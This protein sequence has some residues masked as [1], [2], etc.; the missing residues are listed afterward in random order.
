MSTDRSAFDSHV[1]AAHLAEQPPDATDSSDG[2]SPADARRNSPLSPTVPWPRSHSLFVGS[3]QQQE[4]HGGA[5]S[6]AVK[7]LRSRVDVVGRFRRASF[8]NDGAHQARTARSLNLVRAAAAATTPSPEIAS[9]DVEAEH[10]GLTPGDLEREVIDYAASTDAM[11]RATE[12][13][14]KHKLAEQRKSLADANSELR[15]LREE[16]AGL[17]EKLDVPSAYG[18]QWRTESSET[19]RPL[20]RHRS[21]VLPNSRL[22]SPIPRLESVH[23]S[24]TASAAL[25]AA[26]RKEGDWRLER[27]KL[28]MRLALAEQRLARYDKQHLAAQKSTEERE[29]KLKKQVEELEKKVEE[30]EEEKVRAQDEAE[31]RRQA[32]AELRRRLR[33]W[34]DGLVR[35]GKHAIEVCNKATEG[36]IA[37]TAAGEAGLSAVLKADNARQL[38]QLMRQQLAKC[39]WE[40]GSAAGS[41][42][43]GI[44]GEIGT[45]LER[46]NSAE[47]R[48]LRSRRAGSSRPSIPSPRA[49]TTTDAVS[50]SSYGL[51]R[52]A[53]ASFQ[54]ESPLMSPAPALAA[55]AIAPA[56]RAATVDRGV[57]CRGPAHCDAAA[58]TEP[59]RAVQLQQTESA[60]A[61]RQR[62]PSAPPRSR[63]SP[64][65]QDAKAVP[66]HLLP[67]PADP[68][69]GGERSA[70]S[71]PSSDPLVVVGEHKQRSPRLRPPSPGMSLCIGTRKPSGK[72]AAAQPAP[73]PAAASQ[74]SST[75]DSASPPPAACQVPPSVALLGA[76]RAPPEPSASSTGTPLSTAAVG[77]C[78]AV[79]TSPVL[80]RAESAG[81]CRPGV[82]PRLIPTMHMS[83]QCRAEHAHAPQCSA[84]PQKGRPAR[85]ASPHP[86]VSAVSTLDQAPL[87]LVSPP[88]PFPSPAPAAAPAAAAGAAPRL[89]QFA[90]RQLAACISLWW[91]PR[92]EWPPPLPAQPF[93][94]PADAAWP[95]SAGGCSAAALAPWREPLLALL[96]AWE[97]MLRVRREL[98]PRP[99][100]ISDKVQQFISWLRETLGAEVDTASPR[101]QHHADAICHE[102]DRVLLLLHTHRLSSAEVRGAERCALA[103][104][105]A[106]ATAAT[107]HWQ[108]LFLLQRVAAECQ[109]I[110]EA[111]G[112]TSPAAAWAAACISRRKARA[113]TRWLAARSKAHAARAAAWRQAVQFLVT[114]PNVLALSGADLGRMGG[115]APYSSSLL[116]AAA[117]RGAVAAKAPQR[118]AVSTPP[119]P[120][121]A[122][123]RRLDTLLPQSLPVPETLGV[124]ERRGR[125][126]RNRSASAGPGCKRAPMSGLHWPPPAVS[127]C[128]QRA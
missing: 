29:E 88:S 113:R 124:G 81:D 92:C 32:A 74:D 123:V 1:A 58:Q 38:G 68:V 125:R 117:A 61:A 77:V 91:R 21:L 120:P 17:R 43:D 19:V 76:P 126:A 70:R 62:P 102:F 110:A 45:S 65:R 37:A 48:A 104:A 8:V 128:P 49:V 64:R 93:A 71:Q 36:V 14:Y 28:Q 103:I 2:G 41:D 78:V 18:S 83:A 109:A 114:H 73:P 10:S 127:H 84:P 105:E 47:G 33:Q 79:E 66:M 11:M 111:L 31:S 108:G 96:T 20:T 51:G 50:N 7:R 26:E 106:N 116:R 24:N 69:A 86:H 9:S 35:V 119:P 44:C 55:A 25:E 40:A 101:Q 56:A 122:P 13:H 75:G 16:L 6:G 30:V 59:P 67:V 97:Q 46:L 52:R 3:G 72:K 112:R 87:D 57:C 12:S 80:H 94:V 107:A 15:E 89:V 121:H 5:G 63:S 34:T 85:G 90:M 98:G 82:A 42:V 118:V 115:T 27:G 22:S 4:P 95:H 39:E 54:A 60:T 23:L 100:P 53:R 99:I